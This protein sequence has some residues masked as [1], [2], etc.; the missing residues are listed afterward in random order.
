VRGQRNSLR[1]V[2]TGREV[3][4]HYG[5]ASY[6]ARVHFLGEK[7]LEPGGSVLAEIRF[8][9]PVYVFVGD[10]FVLRNAS[11][12]MT[13]AGG[14]VLD[15][16]ANRRAFR[17]PWQANFLNERRERFDDLECLI[18]SQ[19][20][21]D[22]AKAGDALLAKSRFSSGEIAEKVDELVSAGQLA[23]SGSWI[24]DAAWWS[25]ISAATGG[26]IQEFHRE[27]PDL[28]GMPIKELEPMVTPDL[29]FPKLFDMILEGLMAG[30]FAQA[31]PAIRS[32]NHKPQLPPDLVSAGD[33]IRKVLAA[34]PLGPPNRGEVAP[35][36][37][38]RKALRFLINV[39]EV[40]E[41]D[42][43]TVISTE[44]FEQI[45]S[46]VIDCLKSHDRATASELREA[47]GTSRRFM[48][49]ILERFDEEGLTLRDG[50]YRT[51][52]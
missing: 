9:D 18:V 5:S 7:S 47:A 50:D 34:E 6:P 35:G 27:N 29:P 12:G 44:G 15:E 17:K 21:R 16:D 11:A 52:K 32:L 33:R 48:M 8:R 28:P 2:R 42:Q 19:M 25:E 14:V 43:K 1:P 49:P 23:R 22:K 20:I 45:K 39:G 13:L 46:A 10:R 26:K 38:D 31:G 24:F 37:S 30:D 4:F 36:D 3:L 51:L 41:L 40:V